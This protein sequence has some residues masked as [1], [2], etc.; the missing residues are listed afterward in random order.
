MR[1][2]IWD[3]IWD[4]GYG[5][6]YG[7]WDMGWDLGFGIWDGL[8]DLGLGYGCMGLG[9][10]T[11]GIWDFPK[12]HSMGGKYIRTHHH[13]PTQPTTP[14]PNPTPPTLSVLQKKTAYKKE[15]LLRKLVMLNKIKNRVK[16]IF[17]KIYTQ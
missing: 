7:I 12:S 11:N 14:L 2:G 8:W 17:N 9:Y 5:M 1:Y 16:L 15:T 13:R 4:L 3:G 10:D 6:G